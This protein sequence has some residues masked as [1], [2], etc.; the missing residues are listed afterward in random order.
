MVRNC[1]L[2]IILVAVLT[3]VSG[4]SLFFPEPPSDLVEAAQ[5]YAAEVRELPGV[6]TAEATVDSVGSGGDQWRVRIIVDATSADGLATVPAAVAA[7]QSPAGALSTITVRIPAAPDLARVVVSDAAAADI[8]RAQTL[9]ELPFAESV[10][11]LYGEFTIYLFEDTLVSAAAT[12]VRASG[13]LSTDP[14]D[15]DPL[16]FVQLGYAGGR[17]AVDVSA[18]GPSDALIGLIESFDNDSDLSHISSMEPSAESPRPR[19]SV[20][21]EHPSRVADTLTEFPEESVAGRPRTGFGVSGGDDYIRGFVGLPLGSSEPDDLPVEE[22]PAPTDPAA[23]AAQLAEDAVSVT[24][25]LNATVESS[26]IPG[27]PDVFTGGCTNG[28][29]ATQ[30]TGTLLLKVFEYEGTATRAYDA[31]VAGWEAAGYSHT[32]QATGTS[33]YTSAVPRA[34]TELSIRGTADGIQI[35]AWGECRR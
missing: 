28:E 7:V 11:L 13:V 29:G 17:V 21:A 10:T 23:L 34:V 9:R 8:E 35:W 16:D 19:I 25:F 26:G 22:G 6:T 2:A 18:A 31:I 32:D 1:A 4:C 14:L 5:E 3:A 15:A 20:S 12:G 30:T 33:F 27:A 24:D